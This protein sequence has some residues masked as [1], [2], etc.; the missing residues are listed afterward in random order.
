[1]KFIINLWNKV[2]PQLQKWLKGLEVAIATGV[3]SALVAA[4]SADFR[5]K[6]GWASFLGKIALAA[7]TCTRLYMAQSPIQNVLVASEK[8]TEKTTSDTGAT[9][10]KTTT[11]DV[12]TGPDSALKP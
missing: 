5:S 12:I 4:P 9:T 10:L 8:T 3:V 2:P 1:M 7:A 11:T 6:A